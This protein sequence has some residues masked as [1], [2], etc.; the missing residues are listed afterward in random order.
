[1]TASLTLFRYA[2]PAVMLAECLKSAFG[3]RLLIG[4]CQTPRHLITLSNKGIDWHDH[5]GKPIE[6]VT[7]ALTEAYEAC[8]FCPEVTQDQM[9]ETEPKLATGGELRWLRDPST[10]GLG[11]AVWLS[12]RD[13][14]PTG[15]EP[16]APMVGLDVIDHIVT[17]DGMVT[18][19]I[20]TQ[21]RAMLPGV[22]PG[23]HGC[24]RIREYIGPAPAP[25][26]KHGNHLVVARRIIGIETLPPEVTQS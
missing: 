1:M 4:W 5:A 13:W 12:E 6:D 11:R 2:Q 24:Y 8:L 3:D 23:S 14:C 26:G 22:T 17:P 7:V 19:R 20:V 21:T 16:I 25:A 18:N 9:D 10:V 15:F